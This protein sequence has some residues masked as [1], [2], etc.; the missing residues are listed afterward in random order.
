MMNKTHAPSGSLAGLLV[1]CAV[2]LA[3]AIPATPVDVALIAGTTAGALLPDADHHSSSTAR[4]WGP[5]T[6]IPCYYLGRAAGGHREGTHDISKGAPLAFGGIFALGLAAPSATGFAWCP[7][8]LC[9]L[10][11]AASTTAVAL[12]VGLV[13]VALAPWLPGR[14]IDWP[15][16]LVISW[17]GALVIASLGGLS[18]VV[19]AAAVGGVALGVLTGIAGDACTISG[20]PWRGRDVHLLR[21]GRR[22]RTGS[23]AETT[24]VRTPILVGIVAT[25]AW[26]IATN[27]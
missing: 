20:V 21:E 27:R 10:S 11:A 25:T 15:T 2:N 4:M 6:R 8:W 18:L 5:V 3:A 16:N 1:L 14:R 22:I 26:L 12:I 13:V 24:W 9:T 23:A 17:F 19:I 7:P